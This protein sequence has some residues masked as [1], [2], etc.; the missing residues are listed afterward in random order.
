MNIDELNVFFE[1]PDKTANILLDDILKNNY[2]KNKI[3]V[4]D[5][6]YTDTKINEWIKTKTTTKGG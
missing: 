3:I 2:D 5:N 4:S 1:L 6:V